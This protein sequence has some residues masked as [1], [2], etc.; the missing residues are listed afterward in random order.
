MRS[1]YLVV[2]FLVTA[3]VGLG[4]TATSAA[5]DLPKEP[6]EVFAK[7]APLYDLGAASLKPWYLKAAYQL[8]DEKGDAAER[9]TYE[10]WWA[11]PQVYRETWSR[12]S[13]THTDWHIADGKHASQSTGEPLKF[14]E[15]TLRE[16]LLSPLPDDSD[17]DAA[18]YRL[19]RE[20]V[21]LGSVKYP[22]IMVIPLMPQ[23]GMVQ[24]V[25][26]GLFPT[27]CFDPHMPVL[28]IS[29]S[30]GTLIT[31]FNKIVKMQ[32]KYLAREINLF[33][34][35]RKI[36]SA[37]VDSVTGLSV[38]DPALQPPANVPVS[39]AKRVTFAG[40]VAQGLL[41][42]KQIPIYPEDAKQ[43]RVSGT[44]VLRAIIGIDGAIHQLHVVSA[45][46]P[47]LAASSLQSVSHWQYK[48]CRF[49]GELVEVETTV[50]VVFS[51]SD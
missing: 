45:P 34:G 38:A 40:A 16:K 7:A 39:E 27:Y 20:N 10:Y 37:T 18:K 50:N 15:H 29:Y 8:Y 9:G 2:L 30:F 5:P 41:I 14:F 36:L 35:K 23:H 17:L 19:D 25:P 43:A 42:K 49:N 4:Q 44:V 1:I 21:T 11:S 24:A 22:C 12:P 13:G 47:S 3:V 32:D 46:W 51:L 28:R 26:L 33:E 6:R 31:D 48:P